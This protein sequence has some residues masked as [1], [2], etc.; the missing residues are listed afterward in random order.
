MELL[1]RIWAVSP[2]HCNRFGPPVLFNFLLQDKKEWDKFTAVVITD[3]VT[4]TRAGGS[5]F[6][7]VLHNISWSMLSTYQSPPGDIGMLLIEVFLKLRELV[8]VPVFLPQSITGITKLPSA[9]ATTTVP[10]KARRT[11]AIAAIN[12]SRVFTK[13]RSD[14]SN[15]LKRQKHAV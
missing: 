8:Q 6:L 4:V 7:A 2:L 10:T 11:A 14:Q 12:D 15:R 9:A 13:S 5:T 3:C 1:D